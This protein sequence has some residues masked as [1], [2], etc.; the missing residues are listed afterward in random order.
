[1]N[2]DS[3]T[4]KNCGTRFTGKY[5]SNCRQS[6][7][8][9]RITWMEIL[10]QLTHAI[11]HAD[12]GLFYTIKELTLRPG[13][14]LRE[15]LNG[16]RAYY[17][18]PFLFV[19]LTGGAV[20]LLFYSLHLRPVV[21]DIQLEQL[22]QTSSIVAHKYFI[23]VGNIFV[24]MLSITD[25]LFYYK[26]RYLFSEWVVFNAFQAG[27]IL[28]FVILF[29]PLLVWQEHGIGNVEMKFE[30]RPFFVAIV[31]AYLVFCRIQFLEARKN[32]RLIGIILFQVAIIYMFFQEVVL[33]GMKIFLL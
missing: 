28:A 13:I 8:T 20:T 32:I 30:L 1:M 10:H 5:C 16:K 18:N 29:V 15:Y 4:C 33:L 2:S 21:F 25:Y 17:F 6:A 24:I 19:I 3:V 22:E 7:D 27:Q 31:M 14:A 12:K 26:K 9:H 23:M 11:F